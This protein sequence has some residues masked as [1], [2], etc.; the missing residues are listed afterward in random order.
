MLN[1]KINVGIVG[2]FQNGKSTFVNC[3]LDDLVARTGGDGISVTSVN[4]KYTYGDYQ[5]VSY[6]TEGKK[7]HSVSM[8][9]FVNTIKFSN[10]ID[11]ILIKLWKPILKSINLIDTPGFNANEND[12]QTALNA[13]RDIDLAI[14]LINN[15]AL[16]NIEWDIMLR[17]TQKRIPFYLIM[18]CMNI[19]GK[20]WFPLSD[21]NHQIIQDI[22]SNLLA[23]NIKPQLVSGKTIWCVNLQWFFYVTEHFQIMDIEKKESIEEDVSAYLRRRLKKTHI[24]KSEIVELS[25]FLP[26][27]TLLYNDA[28]WGMPVR[29]IRWKAAFD[30]VFGEW[31]KKLNHILNS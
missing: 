21:F 16:S 26:L 6:L 14:V 11:E 9:D 24:P 27:R 2:G 18:N 23:R 15:K 4:T 30:Q 12:S 19:M 20:S 10:K 25:N 1:E 29:A 13:I 7:S 22:E 28:S 8:S 17:L 5:K 31:E 3:L